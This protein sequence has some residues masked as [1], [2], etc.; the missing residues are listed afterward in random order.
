MLSCEG[1]HVF[2]NYHKKLWSC[3][4]GKGKGTWKKFKKNITGDVT[5]N[6]NQTLYM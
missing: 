4:R 5:D 3:Q 2:Q 6:D 1:Y